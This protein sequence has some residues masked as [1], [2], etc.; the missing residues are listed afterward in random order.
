MIFRNLFS[1]SFNKT[2]HRKL[3]LAK[4]SLDIFCER[5]YCDSKKDIDFTQIP[6]ER[7]R[8]FSIIAHVDHGKST[9]ADRLLEHTGAIKPGGQNQILDKLQVER[10]RGIT[11]KAQTASLFYEY[12]NEQYLLNLIDTP[13][14]VDF[15]NEVSRSLSACQGVILLVD[16]NDGVQ[17][18]TVA[19]FY[20]AFGNDLVII[21][22]LNK[23]D[24]KNADPAKVTQ[25]LQ[26][27]FDIQADEVLKISAKLG[28]GIDSVLE[29]IVTRLPS[30]K[31]ARNG[32][33]K[34]LLFDSSYDKYRGV[35]SLIF[36]KQGSLKVGENI[37]SCYTQKQYEVK[38]LSLLRP[39][40]QPVEQLVAGQIGLVGCNMRSSQE[41]LVGDTIHLFGQK[42]EALPGFQPIRPMVFAGIYPMDQSQHVN[43]RSAIEKLT[44]NDSA[45]SVEIDSSPALGQGW[46]LGFLG[47]LHLEVFSQRLNQEYGAEPI[48]TAP[49]V[50]YKVKLKPTKQNVKEGKDVITINNPALWPEPQQIEESFE[51]M[52]IGTIITPDKYLGPIMS[53]CME[54]RGVQRNATNIDNDRIMLQYDLPLCEIVI[55]FH[56]MLKTISSG[57][58]SFDYEDN[59]YVSS[60]LVKMGVLLNNVAVE[61]LSSIVHITKSQTMGKKLVLRLKEIIPRQMINIAVQAV[62]GG[63]V[64]ARQD[65]KAYRKD[66]TQWLY[67]GDVTRRKKLLAQQ[68]AGKKKM[69]MI[70]NI[71]VPRETFIDVLKK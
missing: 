68:A 28:I 40:E 58:A 4:S 57:Y 42:V 54:R 56:D 60:N 69:R 64:L 9:L 70:A 23:I 24:L 11:V 10:E 1:I 49:S 29:A 32:P 36:V 48:I 15:S 67:G 53:L 52:V 6:V 61:E 63:K 3:K 13:G 34:A 41:A 71:S 16:S 50:I 21:P 35:L 39:Q 65:I 44:L 37:Q 45:V 5:F 66:V 25:Q 47:L 43:L 17:A 14:H 12:N 7:I 22:V 27:L 38:T 19:N 31:V 30:P 59:G 8:N 18:Q 33:L 51:P 62:V 26:S 2:A 20:L 46:R 55:D